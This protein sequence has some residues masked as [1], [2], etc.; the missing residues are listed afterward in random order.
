M[1]I[2]IL[3]NISIEIGVRRVLS[4]MG[5]GGKAQIPV[6]DKILVESLMPEMLAQIDSKIAIADFKVT[7]LDAHS[8]KLESDVLIESIDLARVMKDAKFVS[9]YTATIGENI[10]EMSTKLSESGKIKKAH[11]WDAFGSEAAEAV[12]KRLSIIA[13]QRAKRKN[14][15]TTKRFSPGYGD[16]ALEYNRIIIDILKTS[17]IGVSVT[18]AGLLVPRKSTTGFIGWKNF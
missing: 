5:Y 12:A 17:Q 14:M 7:H 8:L 4:R 16:L 18:D 13:S 6:N 1:K 11:I 2:T 10:E 3:E 9:I 15:I